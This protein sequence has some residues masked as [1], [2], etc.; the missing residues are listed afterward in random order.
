MPCHW[1]NFFIPFLTSIEMQTVDKNCCGIT[2]N[3]LYMRKL[4]FVQNLSRKPMPFALGF[5]VWC[6]N[7]IP[8]C[9]RKAIALSHVQLYYTVVFIQLV[10]HFETL[11]PK[12]HIPC[13]PYSLTR[14]QSILNGLV[15]LVC[16]S[17]WYPFSTNMWWRCTTNTNDVRCGWKVHQITI[18]SGVWKI[19]ANQI[20]D[21]KKIATAKAETS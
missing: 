10:L 5:D 20:E 6:W 4:V 8:L 15:L 7:M 12:H 16:F 13:T 11:K 2:I 1:W 3:I 17:L 19:S 18:V 14:A 21:E 9:I